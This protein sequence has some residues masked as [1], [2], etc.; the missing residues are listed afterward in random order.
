LKYPNTT[1]TGPPGGPLVYYYVL[2]GPGASA[3][4][5]GWVEVVR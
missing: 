5:K 4:V 2:D 3:Q 1:T